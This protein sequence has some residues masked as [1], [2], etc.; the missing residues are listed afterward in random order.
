MMPLANNQSLKLTDRKQRQEWSNN[1][2]SQ[3]TSSHC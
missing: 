1:H 3:H 2:R